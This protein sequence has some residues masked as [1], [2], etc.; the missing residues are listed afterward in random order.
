[1]CAEGIVLR[2]RD[3][4]ADGI[5]TQA[6]GILERG[7][8]PLTLDEIVARRYAV[9]DML[10]DFLGSD[11]PVETVFIA[12]EMAAAATDLILSYHQ[13]WI[14]RGKWVLRALQRF[15]PKLADQLGHAL[16]SY[17]RSHD[18]EHLVRFVDRALDLVGG[19]LFE[20]YYQ[21][22]KNQPMEARRELG[23]ETDEVGGGADSSG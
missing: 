9:T 2:D 1:M 12:T 13:Q 20:G 16:T 8:D 6:L 21:T 17:Q 7:P 18:K 5:R 22:A 10:D 4:L 3:G 23:A 19:R 14:G 11:S 15:D